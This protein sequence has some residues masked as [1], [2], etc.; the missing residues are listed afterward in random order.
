MAQL[1]SRKEN[2]R[3]K[4]GYPRR[5]NPARRLFGAVASAAML[6]GCVRVG[7]LPKSLLGSGL[8]YRK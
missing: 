5:N 1:G 8:D 2:P 3:V 7:P 4:P 6:A